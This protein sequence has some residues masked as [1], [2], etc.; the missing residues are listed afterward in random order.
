MTSATPSTERSTGIRMATKTDQDLTKL[1]G[2]AAAFAISTIQQVGVPTAFLIALLY[3][4]G[5][6]L[7][8]PVVDG[9]VKFLDQTTKTLTVMSET[10]QK[11]NEAIDTL[12]NS[13]TEIISSENRSLNFMATVE[14]AHKIHNDKLDKANAVLDEQTHKLD[15]IVE[16]VGKP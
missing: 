8:P 5:W 11:T 12:N 3:L 9:H 2:P 6:K 7:G 10:L 16:G 1:T 4:V 15:V 14:T 13:V